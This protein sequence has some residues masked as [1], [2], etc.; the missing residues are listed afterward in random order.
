M[1]TKAIR[2]V[3]EDYRDR[4]TDSLATELS[5][6]QRQTDEHNLQTVTKALAEL[7]AI[8]KASRV[9]SDDATVHAIQ[10]EDEDAVDE[11]ADMLLAI[12]EGAP[13]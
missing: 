5:R 8:D 1:S 4:M 3:L 12:A 9:L 10:R 2:A 13:R 7:E 11:A 6:A